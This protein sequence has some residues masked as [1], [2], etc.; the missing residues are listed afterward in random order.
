MVLTR[1]LNFDA[2]AFSTLEVKPIKGKETREEGMVRFKKESISKANAH[3][4]ISA[5][6]SFK[7]AICTGTKKKLRCHQHS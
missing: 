7:E 4:Q 3:Q 2:K 5:F 1:N 6:L